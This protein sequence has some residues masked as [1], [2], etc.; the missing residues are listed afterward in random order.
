MLGD[1]IHRI[2]TISEK[3]K[4]L[5]EQILAQQNGLQPVYQNRLENYT[6]NEFRILDLNNN[7]KM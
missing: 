1:K 5:T 3:R 7:K 6:L 4:K 2:E